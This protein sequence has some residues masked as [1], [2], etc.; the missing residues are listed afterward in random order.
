MI[1]TH[2][3]QFTAANL[4]WQAEV[5]YDGEGFSVI[6]A[7][8]LDCNCAFDGDA[9]DAI[10]CLMP[11]RKQVTERQT[12]WWPAQYVSLR[13]LALAAAESGRDDIANRHRDDQDGAR[14]DHAASRHDGSE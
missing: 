5:S 13:S 4:D 11:E 6:W 7:D 1:S 14:M 9:L 2:L 10:G 12:I 8:R 3:I